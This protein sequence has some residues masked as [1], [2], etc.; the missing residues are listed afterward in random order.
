MSIE[1]KETLG[2]AYASKKRTAGGREGQR[3]FSLVFLAAA[4]V[5]LPAKNFDHPT[6]PFHFPVPFI[7]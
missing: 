7:R 5:S 2:I 6:V 4:A 3:S 1:Y